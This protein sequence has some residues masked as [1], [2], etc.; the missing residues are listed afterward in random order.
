M[1]INDFYVYENI[2]VRIY[3][4]MYICTHMCGRVRLVAITCN[5]L[6]TIALLSRH[7]ASVA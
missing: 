3:T 5:E 6:G 2:H 1:C 4:Y 7:A